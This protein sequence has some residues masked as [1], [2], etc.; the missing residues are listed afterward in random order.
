MKLLGLY[1]SHVPEVDR[2]YFNH[3]L[4]FFNLNIQGWNESE[5]IEGCRIIKYKPT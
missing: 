2:T 1:H 4:N 3:E 5:N